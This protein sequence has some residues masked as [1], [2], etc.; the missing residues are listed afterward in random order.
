[1]GHL[2]ENPCSPPLYRPS[3]IGAVER[4]TE[5]ERLGLRVLLAQRLDQ[6]CTV[7]VRQPKVEDRHVYLLLLL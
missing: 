4:R 2:I 1:V 7:A 6:V 3:H 5:D